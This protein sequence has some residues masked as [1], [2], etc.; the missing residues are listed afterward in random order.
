MTTIVAI[1]L[2]QPIPELM[3]HAESLLNAVKSGEIR[4]FAYVA[5]LRDG[6]TRSY[7]SRSNDVVKQV[8]QLTYLAHRTMLKMEQQP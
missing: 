1:G 6:S 7:L 3:E 2:A 4:G 5:E 8:G